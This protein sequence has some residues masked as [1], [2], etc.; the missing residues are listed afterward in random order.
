MGFFELFDSE[1]VQ[2]ESMRGFVPARRGPFVSA[3]GPKTIFALRGPSDSLRCSPSPAA[4]QLATLR[5]C[6][7]NFRTRVRFSATQKAGASKDLI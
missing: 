2:S 5:Q 1:L 3:K 4:A 7:P 6:S